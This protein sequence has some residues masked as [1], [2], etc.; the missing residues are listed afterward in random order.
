MKLESVNKKIFA[1][2]KDDD[3]RLAILTIVEEAYNLGFNEGYEKGS[4]SILEISQLSR[5]LMGTTKY[6][7][8]GKLDPKSYI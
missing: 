5:K 7:S 8:G 2:V 3:V 4:K 1:N 6:E